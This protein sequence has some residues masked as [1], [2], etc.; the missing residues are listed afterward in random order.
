MK[1]LGANCNPKC[2]FGLIFLLFIT[3][4]LIAQFTIIEVRLIEIFVGVCET[5][6]AI[7]LI[8]LALT[9]GREQ[10][11]RTDNNQLSVSEEA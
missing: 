10:I 5:V 7:V 8:V 9:T 11:A 3:L 1:C 4:C 2:M 6:L